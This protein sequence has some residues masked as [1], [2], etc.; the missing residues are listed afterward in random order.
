MRDN[1]P[2]SIAIGR[3]E[4]GKNKL[5]GLSEGFKRAAGRIKE[6]PRA[7]KALHPAKTD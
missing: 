6:K 2:G 5:L 4:I 7:A 1:F 3:I